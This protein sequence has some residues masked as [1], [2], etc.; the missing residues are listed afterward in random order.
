MAKWGSENTSLGWL[1]GEVET[2]H[3]NNTH[4]SS[5]AALYTQY[6]GDTLA[7]LAQYKSVQYK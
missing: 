3:L 6:Y 7:C 2:L 4:C 5:M 1:S